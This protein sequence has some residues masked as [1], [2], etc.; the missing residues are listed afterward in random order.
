MLKP[1][2][3]FPSD[4]TSAAPLDDRRRFLA[5]LAGTAALSVAAT[6][7]GAAERRGRFED[8]GKMPASAI[9]ETDLCIIGA[10]AAGITLARAMADSGLSVLLLE[11]GSEQID[12]RTQALCR[13]DQTGLPYYDL[14]ACRLRYFGGTTN[15]WAGYSHPPQPADF[16]ARPDIGVRG[17]P[18]R[19]AELTP[20]IAQ[21]SASLGYVD[22]EFDPVV[23]ARIAGQ[24]DGL[25]DAQ[26]PLLKTGLF[27]IARRYRFGERYRAELATQARLR[28]VLN[29]NV[30][31]L[32]LDADATRVREVRVRAFDGPTLR[33]RAARWVLA[34]HALESAR[35]LL[36]SDDVARRGIGNAHDQVGR[37]FM[38]H[39]RVT[40]G[41][42]MPNERFPLIYDEQW[43]TVRDRNW[44]LGLSDAVLRT[45]G[46]LQYQCRFLPVYAHDR[47]R[48]AARRLLA[49]WWDPAD[50]HTLHALGQLAGHL[51]ETFSLLGLVATGRRARPV[52][53]RLEHR[54]EQCPNPASRLTLTSERDALG[55]RKAVFHW[56]LNAVDDR[57][58]AVGQAVLGEQLER[59]GVGRVDGPPLTPEWI[60]GR[61]TGLN[62]HTGTTR[63]S[64]DPRHGVVDTDCKV[65]GVANLYVAGSG[66]FPR[67][68]AFNPTLLI[69]ALALRLAEHLKRDGPA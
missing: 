22:A 25:L 39:A 20:F 9:L 41:V 11:A 46:V 66:V 21:A 17:W 60:R 31:H 49:G 13:W 29:A 67:I 43:A 58:F 64:D 37:C 36:V 51:G 56:A 8:A 68:G 48:A 7:A 26:S 53:Y 61:V 54:I 12:G 30:V 50:A 15:H 40:S 14:A 6:P 42:L 16:D 47:A 32:Q 69:M 19:L 35:L 38:E 63:M 62:H 28:V 52:A 33:V 2:L 23:A 59:L 34:A 10:G 24:A 45:Q 55:V 18:I 44:T 5:A 1:P 57:S 4:D 3:P 27:Q 65:H